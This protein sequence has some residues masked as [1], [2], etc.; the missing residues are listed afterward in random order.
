M[1]GLR[2][3]VDLA[4]VEMLYVEGRSVALFPSIIWFSLRSSTGFP[5]PQV[6][7]YLTRSA[8]FKALF[9]SEPSHIC[10][11]LKSPP[12]QHKVASM[13]WFWREPD[14]RLYI[15]KIF[16]KSSRFANWEPACRIEVFIG[17]ISSSHRVLIASNIAWRFRDVVEA[18]RGIFEGREHL[19]APID[20]TIRSRELED[21]GWGSRSCARICLHWSTQYRYRGGPRS[22]RPFFVQSRRDLILF[23]ERSRV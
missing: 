17:P 7:P 1:G 3:W 21:Q 20:S 11:P 10:S 8:N 16:M 23:T 5:W 6:E 22:V 4:A 15:D 2:Y 18:N 13:G 12:T 19:H 9:K 14:S